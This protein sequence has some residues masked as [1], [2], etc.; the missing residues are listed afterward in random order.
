MEVNAMSLINCPECG[1]EISDQVK[2][3]PNCGYPLKKKKNISLPK[4]KIRYI[5]IPII[6][7]IAVVVGTVVWKNVFNTPLNRAISAYKNDQFDSYK[8]VKSDM[9]ENDRLEFG[10]YLGRQLDEILNDYLDGKIDY[11]SANEI[12]TKINKYG[13]TIAIDNYNDVVNQIKNLNAS[14]Q[15]YEDAQEF[16]A[17]GDSLK[18][19]EKY[20]KVISSDPNYNDAQKKM[21]SLLEDVI[22][23]L[24]S[25]ASGA[26]RHEA[27]E[28][29]IED[30]K[31]AQ[32]YSPN[33]SELEN[34]LKQYTDKQTEKERKEQEEL[35]RKER[36]EREKLLLYD[37]KTIYG[38]NGI[39]GVFE[40]ASLTREINP[41][42]TSGFHM[43]YEP[44]D[45]SE[46]YLDIKFRIQN[47]ASTSKN[48]DEIISNL[49]VTYNYNYEYTSYS[50]F[51]S[52]SDDIDIVY[53]WDALSPLDS[54]TLHIAVPLPEEVK[55]NRKS[56]VA[57]FTFAGEKQILEYK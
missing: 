31:E 8:A 10:K 57:E 33:D 53:S 48:L 7:V 34:L 4:I 18:A 6:L 50:L 21:V 19:Y 55:S 26:A 12:I 38:S 32:K 41:N 28:Q 15:A 29:A 11:D 47:T 3:C 27:Y 36:E 40:G 52:D 22:D 39:Q 54:T 25:S 51:Y 35:E 24:K 20:S 14:K 37:H 44:N 43:Y 45:D 1:K 5:V 46:I 56:L 42:N 23:L 16:E 49:T 13:D 9:N 17:S 30:I 2:N